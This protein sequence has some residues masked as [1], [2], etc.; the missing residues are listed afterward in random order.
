ML[1]PS[2][3]ERVSAKVTVNGRAALDGTAVTFTVTPPLA[4]TFVPVQPTT[5][6]G[7]AESTL[8]VGTLPPSATFQV[9]GTTSSSVNTASDNVTY[10]VRP[11]AAPLQVL[12]PAYFSTT[13]TPSPWVALTNGAQSYPGVQITVIANPGNGILTADSTVDA[14]LGTAIT[15]FKTAQ[16]TNNKVIAYVATAAGSSGTIS[17]ADIKNTVD[18]YLRLYPN[19]LDGFFLDGMATDSARVAYFKEIYDYI[20][21]VSKNTLSVFGNPGTYPVVAYAGITDVLV[22]YAGNAAAYPNVDPQPANTWVYAKPNSAQAMQVH[23]A[24]TCTDMQNAIKNAKRPRMNTGM[25]Y[26]TNLTIGA[27]WSA[28]P[29]YFQ[30]MLGTVDALNKNATLPSC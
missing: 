14:A 10:Y 9:T 21:A 23:T 19:K 11:A 27:P 20:K 25:V 7:V 30:T 1:E 4:S 17:V 5:I 6:L 2:T 28:L 26:V 18:N 29:T 22:T 3:S 13:G 24:S 16:G 8:T 15:A 12:L